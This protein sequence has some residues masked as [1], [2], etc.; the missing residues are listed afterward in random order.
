M[1]RKLYILSFSNKLQICSVEQGS[2]PTATLYSLTAAYKGSRC[3]GP[4]YTVLK[5]P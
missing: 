4:S 1:A 2:C 5:S 3:M